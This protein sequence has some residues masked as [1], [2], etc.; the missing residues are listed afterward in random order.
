MSYFEVV[1]GQACILFS[2]GPDGGGGNFSLN[3]N[4][5]YNLVEFFLGCIRV[6]FHFFSKGPDSG[7]G[8]VGSVFLP[9]IIPTQPKLSYFR[10]VLG[11]VVA[12]K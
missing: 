6:G 11:W 8:G 9:I 2:K 7:V 5:Y 3:Y 12:I 4:T 10:V 1:L